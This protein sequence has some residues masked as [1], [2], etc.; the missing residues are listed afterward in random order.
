MGAFGWR[1]CGGDVTAP[2]SKWSPRKGRAN[3]PGSSRAGGVA[4]IACVTGGATSITCGKRNSKSKGGRACCEDGG[5]E[6]SQRSCCKGS[7]SKARRKGKDKG[8]GKAKMMS[9]RGG[10]M[11]SCGRCRRVTN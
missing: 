8:K 11:G 2:E 7:C 5:S 4:I 6:G 9:W 3:Y 1:R 10:Q